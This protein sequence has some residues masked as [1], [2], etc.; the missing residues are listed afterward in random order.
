MCPLL[1]NIVTTYYFI[2]EMRFIFPSPFSSAPL[3][4]NTGTSPLC[5][6]KQKIDFLLIVCVDK[7]KTNIPYA[8]NVCLT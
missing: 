5:V 4:S 8:F 7:K 2:E 6:F 3:L 1:K